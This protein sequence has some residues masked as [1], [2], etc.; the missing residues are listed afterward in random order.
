MNEALQHKPGNVKLFW[1]A[2]IAEIKGALRKYHERWGTNPS[3]RV[4]L[5][6][7]ARLSN[8]RAEM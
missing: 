6:E 1:G 7:M 5:S 4:L 8:E 2:S 3:P